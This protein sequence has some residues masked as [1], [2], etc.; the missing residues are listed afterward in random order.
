MTMKVAVVIPV[1][2]GQS[3][4]SDCIS[5]C[6]AQTRMPDELIVVDNGSTDETSTIASALGAEVFYE[7]IRGP[8][9]ARNKGWRST[10]A[11]IIAFTDVDCLPDTTWLANLIDPFSNPAVAA[12]G[13][14]IV[15]HQIESRSQR[16]MY[17]TNFIDQE[18]NAHHD[19]LPFFATANA[20]YRRSVLAALEGFDL[21]LLTGEDNDIAWRAQ[22][23]EGGTLIFR[24][25]AVVRHQVGPQ[26][27]ELTSRMRRYAAGDV[28]L[29]R[30][31]SSWPN[32]PRSTSIL[33]RTR[34]IWR[35]PLRLGHRLLTNH[36]YSTPFIDAALAVYYEIGRIQG[37]RS[38]QIKAINP[39]E[40]GSE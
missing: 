17:Q 30:R 33:R 37:H 27:G 21:N 24:P 19:F 18:R 14:P 5:A 26:L 22:I 2:N 6:F 9:A 35:L 31:W 7:G 34:Q 39:I 32:Y 12:V 38:P 1:L 13:G 3:L 29:D 25:N 4:I 36:D 23:L 40:P 28:V 16:W 10:D 8:S 20:A 15:Q 11:E